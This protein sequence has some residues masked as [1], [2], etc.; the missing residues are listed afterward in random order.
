MNNFNIS[1]QIDN[2]EPIP[3]YM[4]IKVDSKRAKN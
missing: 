2:T 4:N 3:D 1:Y